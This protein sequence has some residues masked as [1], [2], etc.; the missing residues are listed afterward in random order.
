MIK[1]IE[2]KRI[3]AE[4]ARQWSTRELRDM[5]ANLETAAPRRGKNLKRV[6]FAESPAITKT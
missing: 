5:R 3:Q 1:V 6:V 4:H 2:G